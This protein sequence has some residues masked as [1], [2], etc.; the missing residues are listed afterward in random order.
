MAA[1]ARGLKKGAAA[2]AVAPARYRLPWQAWA[3]LAAAAL[4][5]LLAFWPTTGYGLMLDDVVLFEKSPTLSDLGSIADGFTKDVGALRKGAETVNSSYY[6]PVFLAISTIYHQA[7]GGSPADW[8]RLCVLMA[9]AIGFLACALF[10]RRGLPPWLALAASAVFSLHP[11]HVSSIAWASGLQEL[12]AAFFVLLA[13]HAA[14]VVQK[15]DG[16][17]VAFGL[18][19]LFYVLAILSKEA[20]L[21]FLPFLG[22]WALA[23]WQTDPPAARRLGRLAGAAGA[24]TLVYLVVRMGVLE[25]RLA[26]PAENAPTFLASLP[27][28][29]VALATYLRLLFW[30]FGFS[31]F[32]PERP[33]LSPF[34]PAVLVAVLVLAALAAGA[35]WAIR[36]RRELAL[37]L[38]F[39][40]CLLLP[41]LNLWVLDP[42]WMVTDRYLFLPSLA[43]P[44]VL[45]LV[46]PR[47]AAIGILAGL[48]IVFGFFTLRYS[49]IF[50]DERTFVAA[51][52]EAEPTSPLIF[53]KRG[54]LLAKDGDPAGARAAYAKAIELDP[55]APEPLEKLG[56]YALQDGDLA[57]AEGFYRRALTVRPYASRGFKLLMLAH[58][59]AGREGQAWRLSDE[60]VGRWPEDFQ[61]RLLHAAFL[62]RGGKQSEARATFEIARKL[63]PGDP[64]VDGGFE[65]AMGRILPSLGR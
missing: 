15:R 64:A 60:A 52:A 49:A 33:F 11:S 56:D 43:L 24:L 10:L 20:A 40:L 62:M 28:I 8:H 7:V 35:F 39:F 51:M 55:I 42:Q 5:P 25:G 37:P 41:V 65:I 1:K 2:A 50:K 12:L 27:A 14:F 63:R 22:L 36:R 31:I 3:A 16:F 30:P 47:K 18:A 26:L 61:V 13:L 17:G 38:A 4:V 34:A 21:G 19:L 44:W 32:R 6:R 48:A 46:L 9:A 53:T 45:A 29:P 23:E 58:A 59:Q 57:A 54:G